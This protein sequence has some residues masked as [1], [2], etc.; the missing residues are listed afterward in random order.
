MKFFTMI[1]NIA[2]PSGKRSYRKKNDYGPFFK[3]VKNPF[4]NFSIYFYLM[5]V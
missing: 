1:L 2:Q 5:T 3:Y 4:H